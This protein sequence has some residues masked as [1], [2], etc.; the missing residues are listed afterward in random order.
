[1]RGSWRRIAMTL[2][3]ICKVRAGRVSSMLKDSLL[4]RRWTGLLPDLSSDPGLLNAFTQ[5]RDT[6]SEQAKIIVHV[7]PQYTPHDATR[8]LEQLFPLADRVLGTELYDKLNV[9]ELS[10]LVFAL[11][12][13][14][15]GMA[16]GDEERA[17]ISGH[18]G[19]V[20]V[21]LL[22]EEVRA[23]QHTRDEAI[24]LGKSDAQVW[25]DYLRRTHAQRSGQ[26][27]RKELV[28]LSQSFAEMVARVAEGHVLD[29]REIRDP[30]QYP[31][32]TALFGQVANIA[33]VATY[34]RLIDLLDLAEDRT[35][36]ALWSIIRPQS[37]ISRIEWSKHR[38]LAPI[39]VAEH[40][41][42]RQVVVSGTTDDPDV[43]AALADLRIW[44][45]VQFAES[46]GLLRDIGKQYEPGLDSTV[47]WDI[48]AS[49]FE[50]VLLRFDFDRSAA[51]G[52]LSKEV[53]GRQRLTLSLIHI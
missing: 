50:P 12:S 48:K 8:H 11:Y 53:Y 43:F 4:Y 13:H 15:W 30:E 20:D 26:R 51:L 41:S 5:L 31:L 38:A 3:T 44:V 39:A 6:V 22:P 19:I 25:E 21:V 27:L 46:I 2:S 9:A 47:R 49:G 14:D 52:L 40:A 45:D 36:F 35:P 24:S 16:V 42:V 1:M 17:A 37:A 18:K 33:A 29:I 10:L 7:F 28:R 23:Y 32:Q 34:V